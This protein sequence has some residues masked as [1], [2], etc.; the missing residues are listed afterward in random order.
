[1]LAIVQHDQAVARTQALHQRLDR[2]AP[3]RQDEAKRPGDGARH[4]L[5]IDRRGQLHQ[6]HPVLMGALAT[7]RV[8]DGDPGLAHPARAGDGHEVRVLEQV[9]DLGQVLIPT[10]QRTLAP[11]Q[12]ADLDQLVSDRRE[13]LLQP[14][15]R[16]LQQADLGQRVF[17][18]MCAERLQA[19]AVGQHLGQG[20]RQ[21]HLSAL[22]QGQKLT[23]PVHGRPEE[24]AVPGSDRAKVGGHAHFQCADAG[25]ALAGEARLRLDRRRRRRL[26][27]GKRGH[28]HP[29]GLAEHSAAPRLNIG[30]EAG[31][32]R[33]QRPVNGRAMI[34]PQ[35]VDPLQFGGEDGD[36]PGWWQDEPAAPRQGRNARQ[37]LGPARVIGLARPVPE[38][39]ALDLVERHR[40]MDLVHS[41]LDEPFARPSPV[42]LRAHPLGANRVG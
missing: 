30:E 33:R 26:G 4:L 22:G 18:G 16:Q 19:E 29:V 35:Q 3:R 42:G 5:G 12:V 34:K 21:Q 25:P 27:D 17:Q 11:W 7:K 10:D 6:P 23:H 37:G 31:G 9:A 2:I 36:E 14:L 28:H 32:R 38:V 24:V 8:L 40:Q 15:R 39:C 41:K 13:V 20:R 1:M